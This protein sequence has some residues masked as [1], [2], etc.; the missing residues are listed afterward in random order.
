MNVLPV[1]VSVVVVVAV[2]VVVEGVVI[3]V[4]VVEVSTVT[5]VVVVVVVLDFV[6]SATIIAAIAIPTRSPANR[7]ATAH[8]REQEQQ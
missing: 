4:V 3:V 2:E 6:R 8:R 1:V 5:V 7:D